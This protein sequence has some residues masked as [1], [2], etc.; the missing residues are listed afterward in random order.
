MLQ[1]RLRKLTDDNRELAANLR[2]ELTAAA[3]KVVPKSTGKTRRGQGSEIGSGRG[4]EERTSS[5]PAAGG[6]GSKRA[7]DNDIE[8]VGDSRPSTRVRKSVSLE[9]SLL[10]AHMTR[11][12]FPYGPYGNSPGFKSD[13]D[14]LYQGHNQA[15]KEPEQKLEIQDDIKSMSKMKTLSRQAPQPKDTPDL[16]SFVHVPRRAA[17]KASNAIALSASKTRS[18]KSISRNIEADRAYAPP[19]SVVPQKSRGSSDLINPSHNSRSRRVAAKVNYEDLDASDNEE[20]TASEA[21]TSTHSPAAL[22]SVLPP[23]NLKTCPGPPFAIPTHDIYSALPSAQSRDTNPPAR[24]LRKAKFEPFVVP[25]KR[26]VKLELVAEDIETILA[27]PAPADDPEFVSH[28]SA[29]NEDTKFFAPLLSGTT[30]IEKQSIDDEVKSANKAKTLYLPNWIGTTH[31][32]DGHYR[33]LVHKALDDST[34]LI[35]STLADIPLEPLLIDPQGSGCP[36]DALKFPNR[37]VELLNNDD[38]HFPNGWDEKTFVRIPNAV[39]VKLRPDVLARMPNMALVDRPYYV[40]QRIPENAPFWDWYEQ[41]QEERAITGLE[42][43]KVAEQQANAPP[44]RSA[45]RSLLY[46]ALRSPSRIE[47]SLPLEMSHQR[48]DPE[49]NFA[50]FWSRNPTD[51]LKDSGAAGREVTSLDTLV[52]AAEMMESC[53]TEQLKP[54]FPA[55]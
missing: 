26:K 1:D 50:I 19:G 28:A 13:S 37:L 48:S 35:H 11:A 46:S 32:H 22:S 45:S 18:T 55:S 20:K 17:V 2:R 23:K 7:R 6:R 21:S 38:D 16:K 53:D 47:S 15:S 24:N 12:P 25:W 44:T 33:N 41:L 51:I 27:K 39:M 43:L 4:S 49:Q 52:L 40:Q 3:P 36:F 34:K 10:D 31:E 29:A 42:N 30:L 54:R 14:S 8:K 9:G 5:V